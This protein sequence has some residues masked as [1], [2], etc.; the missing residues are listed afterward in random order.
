MPNWLIAILI[1]VYVPVTWAADKSVI[2]ALDHLKACN[3]ILD[4]SLREVL[5][6]ET[7]SDIIESMIAFLNNEV[8]DQPDVTEMLANHFGLVLANLTDPKKPLGSFLLLGPTGVG[9]TELVKALIK[10]LGGDPDN[11]LIRVDSGEFQHSSS[12]SGLIGTTQGYAGYGEIPKFHR[13]NLEL[14]AITFT[15]PNGETIKINVVLIDEIEKAGDALAR[16]LLGILDEGKVT[17]GNLDV[18]N[19]RKAFIF[20]TS[21]LGADTANKLIE[22]KMDQLKAKEGQLISEEAADLTGRVDQNLGAEITAS[23]KGGLTEKYPPEFV[24]RWSA[25]GIYRHLGHDQYA[26]ILRKMLAQLQLRIFARG[27]VKLNLLLSKDAQSLV[28]DSGTDFRNGARELVR[29]LDKLSTFKIA[30]LINAKLVGE[31]DV[32]MGEVDPA[33]PGMLKWTRIGKGLSREQMKD[34]A[35]VEYPNY[36]LLEAPF[37]SRDES[38]DSL[39][40]SSSNIFD[41]LRENPAAIKRLFLMSNAPRARAAKQLEGKSIQFSIKYIKIEGQ[42]VELDEMDSGGYLIYQKNEIAE[43]LRS[44]YDGHELEDF[45]KEKVLEIIEEVAGT[46]NVV[47]K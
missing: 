15:L 32:L 44:K 4:E 35:N 10:Y 20:G 34:L 1:A 40:A 30:N 46:S 29:S 36:G 37:E 27:T 2:S 12:I 42:L 16:L 26:K 33:R 28:I 7:K 43:F 39:A 19:L 11:S 8:I 31:G 24:N 21:N 25:T 22:I 6:A 47:K 41:K 38:I 9:K 3:L 23:F 45:S 5:D 18:T 17:M 14:T 13:K